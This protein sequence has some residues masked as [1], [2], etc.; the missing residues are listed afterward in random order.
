MYKLQGNKPKRIVSSRL[1]I[2]VLFISVLKNIN[3]HAATSC[4][5]KYANLTEV[6]R[7]KLLGGIGVEDKQIWA[8]MT[9]RWLETQLPQSCFLLF[10]V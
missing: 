1:C 8:G 9:G 4:S 5:Y 6:L 10:L 7:M 3:Y 2:P